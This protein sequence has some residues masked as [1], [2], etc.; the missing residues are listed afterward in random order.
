MRNSLFFTLFTLLTLFFIGA[1]DLS[2]QSDF[3]FE[4]ELLTPSTDS[5]DMIKYG[6]I[7]ASL[8]TGTINFSIPFYTYQDKDFTIPI[9]FNYSTNGHLPNQKGGILGPDWNLEVGG[10][11]TCEIKGAPDYGTD[12]YGNLS[13]FHLSK[14][15]SITGRDL[16][17]LLRFVNLDYRISTGMFSPVMLYAPGGSYWGLNGGYDSEP[18]LYQFNFMGYSGSFHRG[19]CDTTYLYDTNGNNRDFRVVFASDFSLITII[20][21]DG[22]KYEFDTGVWNSDSVDDQG[23]EIR[24]AWKLTR[25]VAP[26]GRKVTFNYSQRSVSQCQPAS[27]DITGTLVQLAHSG[28]NMEDAGMR[29]EHHIFEMRK[30]NMMLTSI[31]IDNGPTINFSYNQLPSSQSDQFGPI[32]A[33]YA[34][35]T[36]ESYRLKDISV[37]TSNNKLLKKATFSYK[38]NNKGQRINYLASIDITGEG[39]FEMDYYNWDNYSR[40]FPGNGTLSVDHWG[41]YN[42]KNNTNSNGT[43]FLKLGPISNGSLVITS[44]SRD[45]DPSFA[46][47]G[48]LER[49]TYPTGGYTLLDYEGHD[50]S[51]TFTRKN[52]HSLVTEDG[53]CGGLRIKSI[54]NYTSTGE[55]ANWR[56]FQYREGSK[57]SGVLLHFPIYYVGYSAT[58]MGIGIAEN[59]IRYYSSGINSYSTTHIEYSKVTEIHSD[60]SRVVYHFTNSTSSAKYCDAISVVEI[61]DEPFFSH[62][63]AVWTINNASLADLTAPITSRQ[64]ERGK[65]ISREV[66]A[67]STCSTPILTESNSYNTNAVLDVDYLPAYLIR[68]IGYRTKY[69]DNY[70]QV[71]STVSEVRDGTTVTRGEK[72][73]YNSNGQLV[74]SATINSKGDSLITK[75][76]YVWDLPPSQITSNSIYRYMIEFNII[77]HP[78]SEMVY[79]KKE[80][81]NIETLISGKRYTYTNPVIS[82][83]AIIKLSKVEQYDVDKN[84]WFTEV[85]YSAFDTKG[86]LLESRDRNGISTTY[87]WGYGGLY[88]VVKAVN[89][90]LSELKSLSY[91][92]AN[93]STTPLPSSIGAPL[94]LSARFNEPNASFTFFDYIPFVGLS[95]VVDPSGRVTE[96]LYNS[97]GKLKG[98]VDGEGKIHNHYFYSPD[99]KL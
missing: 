39:L 71:G 16:S 77:K 22:Y 88:L 64:A 69:I 42:G 32:A 5:W 46:K 53:V 18:D 29:W 82:N 23:H 72:Y 30:Y 17:K 92:F 95:K 79:L 57:S 38:N 50:Y 13:F 75:F 67:N 20:T 9:G 6:S 76:Q 58:V 61:V 11:I 41:Y 1:I 59:N 52:L 27:I 78:L 31:V 63:G 96:Y 34:P 48:M 73:N 36:L 99:N 44:T 89:L 12:S 43:P 28:Q 33:P 37:N 68:K 90:K 86:N 7:G 19:Y 74:R 65:L 40:P 2:A 49:I 66:F 14:D 25:I 80:G 94:Q 51:K 81:S 98:V 91:F 97:S 3:N 55:L 93:I 45:C 15:P 62:R 10:T 84:Q 87:V 21:S 60:S 70:K 47:N 4:G 56:T 54:N 24:L 85:E 8:Y 35:S 83:R 26:N